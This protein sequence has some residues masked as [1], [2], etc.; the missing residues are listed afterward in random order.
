MNTQ[1]FESA[2]TRWTYRLVEVLSGDLISNDGKTARHSY[3]SKDNFTSALHMVS[4]WSNANHVVLGLVKSDKQKM[5][6]ATAV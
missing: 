4:A 1:A 3:D 6:E 2:F 5:N